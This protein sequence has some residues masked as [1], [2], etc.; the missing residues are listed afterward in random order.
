M[1]PFHKQQLEERQGCDAE[2]AGLVTRV[3]INR[4]WRVEII[5]L[6]QEDEIS[7]GAGSV[8]DSRAQRPSP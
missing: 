5:F 6:I 1:T 3:I 8:A 7:M 4:V 2:D